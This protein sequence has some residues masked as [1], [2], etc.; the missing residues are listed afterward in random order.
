M[1]GYMLQ[2]STDIF[3]IS[4]L[5]HAVVALALSLHGEGAFLMP[6]SFSYLPIA[7]NLVEHGVYSGDAVN[8]V[9]H[10]FRTPLYPLFLTPFVMLNVPIFFVAFAQG[11]LVSL[12][13]VFL[14][15]LG[16]R[17]FSEKVAVSAAI[18]LGIE[19]GGVFISNLILTESLFV[20][21][22]VPALFFGDPR[23][24]PVS[25]NRTE[26]LFADNSFFILSRKKWFR[27]RTKPPFE[28]GS[29]IVI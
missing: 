13:A 23:H 29:I 22:F 21:L 14:Y 15:L 25:G 8:L 7:Q 20:F 24:F 5:V 10:N 3:L 26:I 4:L 1:G 19:P 12:A 9:P 28:I 27:V 18:L 11:I 16:R 2:K 6:D 17:L